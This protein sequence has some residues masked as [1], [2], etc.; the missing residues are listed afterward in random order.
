MKELNKQQRSFIAYKLQGLE[1]MEAVR[2]A[3]PNL[4]PD[5]A[6][7]ISS[8]LK[9]NPQVQEELSR[10]K[11]MLLEKTTDKEAKF[12]DCLKQLLPPSEVAAKL[13]ELIRSSDKRI[14]DSALD[15]YLKLSSLYPDTKIGLYRDLEAE[16][17]KV[18]SPADL[19][20]LLSERLAEQKRTEIIEEGE[21]TD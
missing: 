9:K 17:Q 16:R 14:V 3:Y 12:I 5:S 15:K 19:N 21:I 8:R 1:Q 6:Y 18:I 10:G 20:K 11:D 13:C 4:T 2:R 7:V